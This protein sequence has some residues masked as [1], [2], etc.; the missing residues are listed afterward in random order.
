M[1]INDDILE[2]LENPE[3][4]QEP[5]LK[6]LMER[7]EHRYTRALTA[8]TQEAKQYELKIAERRLEDYQHAKY[9]EKESNCQ[10]ISSI[11]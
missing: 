5:E 9:L 8:E 10:T 3:N 7:I 4:I 6:D 11:S 1:S 2:K